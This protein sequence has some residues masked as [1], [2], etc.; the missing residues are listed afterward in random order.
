VTHGLLGLG[1]VGT[2]LFGPSA[3]STQ[4]A[5]TS[6]AK[7]VSG[8][9]TLRGLE[10]EPSEGSAA[11]TAI[12]ATLFVPRTV[13][14]GLLYSFAYG[15]YVGTESPWP[16]RVEEWLTF[17][18]GRIGIHPLLSVGSGS[19]T[20]Y[21]AE[22]AY[23]VPSFG[24][25]VSGRY[26]DEENWDTK[27]D[28]VSE[29]G[30]RRLPLKLSFSG[31]V[32][33]RDDYEF[34]GFGSDPRRDSRNHFQPEAPSDHG[35]YAQRLP[36]VSMVLAARV[37]PPLLLS[38]TSFY[39]ERHVSDP[40]GSDGDRLGQTFDA[41]TLPGANQ[42]SRQIYEEASAR[43]DTRATDRTISG[44]LVVDAYAGVS[45]GVGDDESRFRRLGIDV[46]PYIPIL[47]HD[48]VIAP[49]F[50]L[51]TV[52]DLDDDVSISFADYPRQPAFRGAPTT[53]LLRTDEISAVPSLEYKW[54]L[55]NVLNGNLFVDYLLVAP[56]VS[57]L[58][59]G[60]A[61]YAVG[62]GLVVQS[63]GSELGRLSVAGG[64]EGLRILIEL[65]TGAHLSDR[66]RWR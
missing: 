58:S 39:Q 51:D 40:K 23:R 60:G 5:D 10:H 48:R 36:R 56:S 32:N 22:L 1:I 47:R 28:V 59:F 11:L 62:G 35:V 54:P 8:A 46:M 29:F 18:H 13:L 31:F 12:N 50:I 19:T 24:A 65:G 37:T 61:P 14:G 6:S 4:E 15:A 43:F 9:P 17:Y 16:A 3:A 25:A 44:G 38:W 52:H 33:H 21:G 30:A 53:R 63:E 34:F 66:T 20:G 45:I 26:G 64:S 42:K 41:S 49:R 55:I 7:S 27:F 57:D 2:I